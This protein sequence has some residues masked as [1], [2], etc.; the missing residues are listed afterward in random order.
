MSSNDV[1]VA[2]QRS[3][4]ILVTAEIFAFIEFGRDMS[5]YKSLNK[6]LVP[7]S[8]KA[9]D[10]SSRSVIATAY[11]AGYRALFQLIA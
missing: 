6:L 4:T 7:A 1:T 3:F 5:N 8:F 2:A 9:P 10:G 11:Q